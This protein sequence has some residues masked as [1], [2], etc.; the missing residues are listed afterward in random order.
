[1]HSKS[2][3][4][5]ANSKV[6][7]FVLCYSTLSDLVFM[8]LYHSLV[9]YCCLS[10]IAKTSITVKVITKLEILRTPHGIARADNLSASFH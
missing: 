2:K 1:M 10:V 9:S 6:L 4:Q 7:S 8:C 3:A 5:R